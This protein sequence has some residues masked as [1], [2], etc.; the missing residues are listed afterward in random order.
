ML[1]MQI[2]L[3][4]SVPWGAV[5]GYRDF[6]AGVVEVVVFL[7]GLHGWWRGVHGCDGVYDYCAD[8][9]LRLKRGL[10]AAC[11]LRRI[12]VESGTKLS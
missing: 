10:A 11:E 9:T 1:V 4:V 5:S 7:E 3:C 2:S 8:E 6:A 12:R